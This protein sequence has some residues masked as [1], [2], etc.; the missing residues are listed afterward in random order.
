MMCEMLLLNIIIT[1]AISERGLWAVLWSS[2]LCLLLR[3]F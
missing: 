2:S 3:S 1:E